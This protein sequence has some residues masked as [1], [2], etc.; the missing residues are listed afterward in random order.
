MGVQRGGGRGRPAPAAADPDDRDRDDLRAAADGARADRRGRLHLPAAGRGGHRRSDQL[1]AADAGAGADALHD[2]RRTA[3]SRSGCDAGRQGRRPGRTQASNPGTRPT[4]FD[5]V[6]P[7][8][9]HDAGR[10]GRCSAP[11]TRTRAGRRRRC[12]R[13]PTSSRCCACP[14]TG[15]PPAERGLHGRIRR[16]A[17]TSAGA[18][19][20][21]S[22]L[23]GQRGLPQAVRGRDGGVRVRLVRHGAAA[24][25]AARADRQRRVGRARCWPPT[26]GSP[27]CCCRTPARS[28]TGSTAARS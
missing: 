24:G 5:D 28:P 22:V 10:V 25:A 9:G 12:S 19:P 14:A 3:R 2:G 4:N 20:L 1:D 8:P 17:V 6:A 13:A 21:L 27:R 7:Q 18:R 15:R 11:P 23:P 26:P 16:V